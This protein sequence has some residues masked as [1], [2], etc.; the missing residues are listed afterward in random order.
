MVYVYVCKRFKVTMDMVSG[1]DSEWILNLV[2]HY[3]K[4]QRKEMQKLER[5]EVNPK[6]RVTI[7]SYD[8]SSDI[9]KINL[10]YKDQKGNDQELKWIIKVTRSDVNE[11][12]NQLMRHEKQIFSRLVNDL[13]NTVKQKS[14][15]FLEGARVSP[16]EL[17]LTPDFV[18]EETSHAADVSRNVLVLDNLEEKH[19]FALTQGSLNLSHFR[20]AVKTIAKFHAVGICHKYMLLDSFEKQTKAEEQKKTFEDIEVEGEHYL[21]RGPGEAVQAMFVTIGMRGGAVTLLQWVY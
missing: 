17:I 5:A 18:Y 8:S 10:V 20:C 12:A 15:G 4:N 16:K 14:A 11:T 9:F 1:K 7:C 19:F 3:L 21:G 6:K 2:K 13:I